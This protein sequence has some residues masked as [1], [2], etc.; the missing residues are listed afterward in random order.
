M[1]SHTMILVEGPDGAGKT[2]L[3]D[4]LC[5]DLGL[6]VGPRGTPN[7]DELYKVTREDAYKALAHAVEGYHR[8]YIWD[9]LGPISDPIYSRVMGRECAF[10]KSELYYALRILKALRCP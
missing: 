6:S 10:K 3:V 5:E 2:T 8:P 9:R 7:R 4:Q 1:R